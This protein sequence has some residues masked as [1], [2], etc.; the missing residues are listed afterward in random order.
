MKS[1]IPKI[2][3]KI[4]SYLLSEEGKISKQALLTM[5][6]FLG[7]AAIGTL[8]GS[9]DVAAAGPCKSGS[10]CTIETT[11]SVAAHCNHISL[12]YSGGTATAAHTHHA[13]Y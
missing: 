3:K 1:K 8:I 11:C 4:S 2:K 9:E 10:D 5:G 6:A 13:S 12:S 7:G